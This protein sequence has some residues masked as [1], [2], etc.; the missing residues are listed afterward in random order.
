VPETEGK[1][2]ADLVLGFV[3]TRPTGNGAPER[4]SGA[5]DLR[6]WLRSA[7]LSSDDSLRVTDADAAVARELRSALV[8]QWPSARSST[9]AACVFAGCKVVRQPERLSATSHQRW[10]SFGGS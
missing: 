1:R 3:N 8:R 2:A 5:Q 4:M 10:P 6:K 7:G 9:R